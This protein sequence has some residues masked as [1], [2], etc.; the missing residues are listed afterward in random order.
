MQAQDYI[1]KNAKSKLKLQHKV[2]LITGGGNGIG[3]A[4]ALLF[5]EEGAKVVVADINGDSGEKTVTEIKTQGGEATYVNVHVAKDFD[6]RQM[7]EIAE[8]TYG[9]LNIVFNNAGIMHPQDQDILSTDEKIWDLTLSVNVKSIF[10]SC[11]YV[12]PALLRIGGGSIIN[13]ASFVALC[14]L[15]QY[16]KVA[17]TA[18]KGA[19]VALTREL[20]ATY[21]KNNIRVNAL[22]PGPV[23]TESFA[24]YFNDSDAQKNYLNR[25]PL[26][27]FA[28]PD[29]IAKAALYLA[30][31]DSS[32]V[33]GST[34]VID[35][36][37]TVT[38]SF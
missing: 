4:T 3:R 18:S 21:A 36:G 32:F 8:K 34:F 29:E 1:N 13:A 5:A 9:K 25:I 28:K 7:V 15:T 11:K 27:R 26:R 35:G 23:F 30:S 12:I 38:H 31:D 20:A 19:V 16:S 10:L 24:K 22:C 6:C 37:I 33:T 17:Y 2:A 14:G